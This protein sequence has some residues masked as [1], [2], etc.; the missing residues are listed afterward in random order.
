MGRKIM[1]WKRNREKKSNRV[2]RRHRIG[3]HINELIKSSGTV[4][5]KKTL[6]DC[7]F[8]LLF[9]ILQL[10]NRRTGERQYW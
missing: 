10:L 9:I 6:Y 3:M 4:D 5:S 7:F 2:K 1:K 8:L